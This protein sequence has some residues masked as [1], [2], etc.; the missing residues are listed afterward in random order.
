MMTPEAI[1]RICSDF[2]FALESHKTDTE[3]IHAFDIGR[4]PDGAMFSIVIFGTSREQADAMIEMAK[5][6]RDVIYYTKR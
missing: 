3:F 1:D 4:A 6:A 2:R 5:T